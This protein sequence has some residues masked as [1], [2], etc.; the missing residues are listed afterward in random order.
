[1]L[2]LTWCSG[3]GCR[4]L[5]GGET[6]GALA[7]LSMATLGSGTLCPEEGTRAEHCSSH[8]SALS[9]RSHSAREPLRREGPGSTDERG[10][11]IVAGALRTLEQS[12]VF[13]HCALGVRERSLVA[14]A[15]PTERTDQPAMR[16]V[17]LAGTGVFLLH[18]TSW[19]IVTLRTASGRRTVER[20]APREQV[21][22]P[23]AG[24]RA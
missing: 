23:A 9:L 15:A 5:I 2:L 16:F 6:E 17:T 22:S 3:R 20:V 8:G 13:A 1:M 11:R 19:L 21:R 10:W 4:P 14:L 7:A 18:S 12:R 24:V